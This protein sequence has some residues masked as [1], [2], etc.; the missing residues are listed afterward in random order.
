MKGV[1]IGYGKGSKTGNEIDE[2]KELEKKKSKFKGRI[3]ALNNQVANDI[4]KGDDNDNHED[5]G[6]K[7]GGN[8]IMKKSGKN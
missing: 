7:F 5:Y 8:N 2:I 1:K 6:D 4:D 3:K